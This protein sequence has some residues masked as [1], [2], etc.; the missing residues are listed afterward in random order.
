MSNGGVRLFLSCVS[1]EFGVYRDELR[2]ALTSVNVEVKIQEDFKLSGDDT[3]NMLLN[4]IK[5]CEAVVHFIGEMAGAQPAVNSVRNLLVDRPDLGSEL[6]E[7]GVSRRVQAK[8]SYTQWEAWL[9]IA[10]GKKVLIVKPARR[11]KR[12]P[13]YAPN[14]A[15]RKSQAEHLRR[16]KA[17][18]R[19]PGEAFTNVDN[20]VAQIMTS[21]VIDELVKAATKYADLMQTARYTNNYQAVAQPRTSSLVVPSLRHIFL[22][23]PNV[24]KVVTAVEGSSRSGFAAEF[25]SLSGTQRYRT[26]SRI[27]FYFFAFLLST[28]LVTVPIYWRNT[29]IATS[30]ADIGGDWT[31]R[32]DSGY[33]F[34]LKLNPSRKNID[35]ILKSSGGPVGIIGAV[36][37]VDGLIESSRRFSI[38]ILGDQKLPDPQSGRLTFALNDA[39]QWE[40]HGFYGGVTGPPSPITCYLSN[41]IGK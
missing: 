7:L 41:R 30:A 19:H 26:N 15:S 20:L 27:Y 14:D 11:V 38:T 16:L 2:H 3:L 25:S 37:K 40:G 34:D 36:S 33:L 28:A 6:A 29:E 12:G 23:D 21:A 4:Y 5:R 17:V 10:L 31:V 8:L 13:N 1:D 9:G 39:G 18:D 35:G 32:C 22:S 24:L